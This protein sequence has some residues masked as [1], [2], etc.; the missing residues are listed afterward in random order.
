MRRPASR[1]W[2]PSTVRSVF[3]ALSVL[4]T[5]GGCA[6][7]RAAIE[8]TP[9]VAE[10]PT[11]R[12]DLPD[13]PIAPPGAERPVEPATAPAAEPVAPPVAAAIAEGPA[14]P[15]PASVAQRDVLFGSPEDPEPETKGG[16]VKAL[17]DVSY[18]VGNEWSLDAF[19]PVVTD[20]G[21]GYVGVGPDQAYLLIGWQR[22]EFAWLVDYDSKVMRVHAMYRAVFELAPT[23]KAFLDAFESAHADR[24]SKALAE[25]DDDRLRRLYRN[26][27]DMFRWRLRTVER[28]LKRRGVPSWLTDDATYAFVR[29]M[30]LGDRVRPLR[31]N[32]N[33][34]AGMAGIA[35]SARELGV[36]IRVVYLS[37]A[38]EYW[39]AYDAQFTANLQGLP[40]DDRS[41]VL[42]TR[43]VWQTNRDYVYNAQPLET[44]LQWLALPEVRTLVDIVGEK[45]AATKDGINFVLSDRPPPVA[46]S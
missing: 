18:I 12:S 27:R 2:C 6:H 19:R 13:R 7:R 9:P 4:A 11:P 26:N 31:V 32:L 43:L 24:I 33:E 3:A 14:A 40:H 10:R 28:K 41:L 22:P 21:G 20:L 35:D 25:H 42:R 16:I 44:F 39:D 29:D 8:A 15:A 38:E 5:S 46:G 45:P 23:R 34:A 30:V 36:P 17:E 1:T 37:N